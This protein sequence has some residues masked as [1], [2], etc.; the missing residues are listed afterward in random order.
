MKPLNL[1]EEEEDLSWYI[2]DDFEDEPV[3]SLI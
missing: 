2:D 3:K 1:A